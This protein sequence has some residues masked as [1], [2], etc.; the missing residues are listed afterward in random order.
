[1]N[2]HGL[3]QLLHLVFAFSYVGSL[4]LAE[5]NSRAARKTTSWPE[6]ARLFEII[7]VSSR[8][9]GAGA[10]FVTGLLGHASA[11]GSGYRMGE[12]RWMIVVTVVWL[13][14]LAGMLLLNLPL[15]ARLAA[16]ARGA[17]DGGASDGWASALARWR[18]A[19]VL[20]SVLY[21]VTLGLMVFPWKS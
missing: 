8:I 15:S 18:F 19:N 21:L 17:A 13:V 4:T 3:W 14:A 6:R 2:L 12:D 5:W 7:H 11:I 9:A 1:M 10:L 20:Q 16:I